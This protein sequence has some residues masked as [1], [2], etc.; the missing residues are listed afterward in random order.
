[1][2]ANQGAGSAAAGG[3]RPAERSTLDPPARSGAEPPLRLATTLAIIV[4]LLLIGHLVGAV[5]GLFAPGT[6]DV[7]VDSAGTVVLALGVSLLV[8]TGAA[9][10]LAALVLSILVVVRGRGA[11]RL[12]A[13]LLLASALGGMVLSL[14]VTGD[15]AMLPAPMVAAARVMEALETALAVIRFALDAAGLILLVRGIRALRGRRS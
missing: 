5:V 13:A 4:T 2:N 12:G 15:P 9:L 1:M 11:L 8:L 7:A 10:A 14:E 6:I 3:R